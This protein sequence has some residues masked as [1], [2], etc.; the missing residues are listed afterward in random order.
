MFNKQ[1]VFFFISESRIAFEG[2]VGEKTKH[3]DIF[4]KLLF[5]SFQELCY[6]PICYSLN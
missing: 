3:I 1:H 2:I 4:I 5:K 6:E